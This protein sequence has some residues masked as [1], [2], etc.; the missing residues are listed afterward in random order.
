MNS[1]FPYPLKRRYTQHGHKLNF[2]NEFLC[3]VGKCFFAHLTDDAV[4][5]KRRY[6]P[7]ITISDQGINCL[8]K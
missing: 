4:A 8:G 6:P 1:V 5:P 7:Y 2:L 3:R